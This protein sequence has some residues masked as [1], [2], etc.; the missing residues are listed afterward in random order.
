MDTPD[1]KQSEW[2][3]FLNKVS[4]VKIGDYIYRRDLVKKK[5]NNKYHTVDTYRS[6]L[7]KLGI[8]EKVKP[9]VYVKRKNIR[10]NFPLNTLREIAYEDTWKS[11]F[12][13]FD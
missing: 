11:W 4:K 3:K 13:N 5:N 10:R 6:I 9:G 12:Y 2:S 8:L 1:K 7:T